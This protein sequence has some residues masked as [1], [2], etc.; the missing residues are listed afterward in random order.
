MAAFPIPLVSYPD[1]AQLARGG[2]GEKTWTLG[3]LQ[4]TL[5]LALALT[6]TPGCSDVQSQQLWEGE[7]WSESPT[8]P[9]GLS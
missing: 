2:L 4:G 7:L 6:P 1:L 9:Q 5:P 3:E 8:G